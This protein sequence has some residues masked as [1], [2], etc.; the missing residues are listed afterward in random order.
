MA[1]QVSA[2]DDA[3]VEKGDGDQARNPT[4]DLLHQT[5]VSVRSIGDS[6]SETSVL[7]LTKW[8]PESGTIS[9]ILVQVEP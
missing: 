3:V 2:V 4:E 5:V 6:K 1:G 8:C 9:R 7:E